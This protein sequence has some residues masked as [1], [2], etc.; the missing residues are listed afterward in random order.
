[1]YTI[2]NRTQVKMLNTDPDVVIQIIKKS[3]Q[4]I[5]L[6]ET[7]DDYKEYLAWVAEGNI[8]DNE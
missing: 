8:A 5:P 4:F 3:N 6:D 1:M 7:N 2:L